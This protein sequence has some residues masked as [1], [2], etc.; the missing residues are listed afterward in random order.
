MA[1]ANAG[2]AKKRRKRRAC[3]EMEID[4]LPFYLQG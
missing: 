1:E 3:E 2:P 4:F